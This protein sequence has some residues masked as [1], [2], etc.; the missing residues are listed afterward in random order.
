MR[1]AI[2]LIPLSSSG[3]GNEKRPNEDKFI[4]YQNHQA[5]DS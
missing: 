4:G 1:G 3:M 2:Y 5:I